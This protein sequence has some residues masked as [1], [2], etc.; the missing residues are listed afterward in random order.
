MFAT[1]LTTCGISFSVAKTLALEAIKRNA[2]S[3]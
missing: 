1:D 2:S 3:D